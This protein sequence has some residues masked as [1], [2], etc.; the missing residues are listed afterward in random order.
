MNRLID[1]NIFLAEILYK[2]KSFALA[3]CIFISFPL[4]LLD[5]LASIN[6]VPKSEIY[7][8]QAS[9]LATGKSGCLGNICAKLKTAC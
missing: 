9:N 3:P 7:F 8:T 6:I 4:I 1:V 2:Y 5:A